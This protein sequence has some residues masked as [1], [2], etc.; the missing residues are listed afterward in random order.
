MLRQQIS[1]RWFTLTV[2]TLLLNAATA[3]AE[4]FWTETANR[5]GM[6]G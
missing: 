2:A 1:P 5:S 6:R 4:P 3:F